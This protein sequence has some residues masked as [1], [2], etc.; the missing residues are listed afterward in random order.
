LALFVRWHHT[1]AADHAA[2][3]LTKPKD[4]R[5]GATMM[6]KILSAGLTSLLGL[7]AMAAFPPPPPEGPGSPPPPAKKKK[8][9]GPAGDLRK[10]YDLLRRIRADNRPIGR[11][12]ERLRD[13]T[14]RATRL[15]RDGIR[16][17]EE[18]DLRLA[19]EYGAS[20]HDLA[21]AV[22]HVRNASLI[23][24]HDSELPPPPGPGPD[25]DDDRIRSDLT[26]AY[27]RIREGL[28]REGREDRF[29]LGAARELYRA[30]RRDAIAGR[31]ERAGEL[32]RAA[33]A[34]T[35]VPEHLA[36]AAG[37]APEPPKRKGERPEPKRPP[38]P[39]DAPPPRGEPDADGFPPPL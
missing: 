13:W 2:H 3:P 9:A 25:G 17:Y 27:E 4:K 33:E 12:E 21:R 23:E 34:I 22:D 19:H 28:E 10:A 29:Y 5:K 24:G 18:R 39:F 8:E 26:H 7:A 11:P 1:E 36:H 38:H 20:A 31:L 30:A 35:H 16:A 15:Y 37:E 32:A 6:I 14:E